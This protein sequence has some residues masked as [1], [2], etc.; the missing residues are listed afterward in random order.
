MEV[1]SVDAFQGREKDFIILSCVRANEHQGIGFLNDP[2]RLNVALTRARYNSFSVVWD[3]VSKFTRWSML[4]SPNPVTRFESWLHLIKDFEIRLPKLVP[5][6]VLQVWLVWAK[7]TEVLLLLSSDMVS[8]SLE[9]RRL[10]PSNLCG[11][12]CSHI[13]RSN[14][15]LSKGL[16]A[17]WRRAWC[18]FRNHASLPM[19]WIPVV[20]TW[21]L[22]CGMRGSC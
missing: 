19:P 16:W 2:R 1:A 15:L 13:S 14:G 9:A 8:S 21:A 5:A 10:F 6:T 20:V 22:R 3:R 17:T 18:S 7:L 11:I 12:I 4:W